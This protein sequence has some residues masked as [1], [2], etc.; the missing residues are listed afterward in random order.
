MDVARNPHLA[1]NEVIGWD[2]IRT[3][4]LNNCDLWCIPHPAYVEQLGRVGRK[5]RLE[6]K[7]YLTG[8]VGSSLGSM[9]KSQA[10]KSL[11]NCIPVP[12]VGL[13]LAP[14]V[15]CWCMHTRNESF[16]QGGS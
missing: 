4:R 11:G 5:L 10:G 8:I 7:A 9:D 1:F 16:M 12:M 3:L 2:S 6:E 15:L 13:V 14:V